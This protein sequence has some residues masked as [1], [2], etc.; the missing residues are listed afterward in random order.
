[1]RSPTQPELTLADVTAKVRAAFGSGPAVTDSAELSGGGFAAVW[2]VRLSDGRDVVLKV[3]PSPEVPLLTYEH[4][5]IACEADYFRL[6][7]DRLP[8]VP[9]PR[10]LHHGDGWLIT[11]FLPG[12]PLSAGRG[13]DHDA[14]REQLG[15]AVARVH[16]VTGGHFGYPGPRPRAATWRA[17][18]TAMVEAM[19]A[20]AVA[21]RVALPVS[22]DLIR[23]VVADSPELD[24]VDRPALVHFDLWD[25]N[26]LAAGGR[27]TGLVDG[28][29]YLYGDPLVDFVSPLL[30][31]RAED[32]PEHPFVRGYAAATGTP[33]V[34]DAPARRRLAL[35]R[36]YLYLLM[37]VEV[38][39]RGI[40]DEWRQTGLA[41][42]LT[43]EV[44]RLAR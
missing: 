28:E 35:Y 39:S 44:E 41:R 37:T 40:T 16:T 14:V 15:R 2:R 32:E 36:L 18:F 26:V 13:E 25:G 42:L 10:V 29:R 20:D 31:R 34:F 3:G 6:V 9:T 4:G 23:A 27:L 7:A 24:E 1:M 5:M 8:D 22:A 30:L 11:T 21:W 38:P 19:L 33:V 17:A 43:E 12:V